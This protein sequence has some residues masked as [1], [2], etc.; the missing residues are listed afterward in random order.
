M[1]SDEGAHIG[2]LEDILKNTA[3]PLYKVKT[4]SGSVYIPGVDEYI[5][6]TDIAGKTI[7]VK[8]IEGLLDL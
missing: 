4:D 8:L 5:L 3:Q 7:K 2:T 6:D 1:V